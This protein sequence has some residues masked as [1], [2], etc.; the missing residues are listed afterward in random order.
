MLRKLELTDENHT[1]LKAECERHNIK[2]LSTG[3]D[4][5]SIEYLIDLGIELIKIPSGEVTNF[6]LLS[7][8]G[9]KNMPTVLSTGMSTL[10]EVKQAAKVLFDH[11]LDKAKLT[12]LHCNTEYP[13]P[14]DDVNLR[15]MLTIKNELQVDIGYSDHT[16]GIEVA[17]A[18]VAMGASIIEK[19]FTLDKSLPGPDHRASLEPD[20]LCKMISS[21]RN[22]EKALG[23]PIKIPSPSE[24]K[25][26]VVARKS[27]VASKDIQEGE[28][29]SPSN[30]TTK[31]PGDGVSPMRWNE[32][33]GKKSDRSY[34]KDEKIE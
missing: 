10:Q 18:S 4:V 19:H 21:I 20:E 27:I 28:L 32:Y 5:E 14:M 29:F 22:I 6:P 13:T 25:N 30:L 24:E 17:I 3:F 23:S 2:F 7:Y 33:V 8:V 9:S 12:V 1:E 15:A 26:K 31:R 11:G 16:T 34:S